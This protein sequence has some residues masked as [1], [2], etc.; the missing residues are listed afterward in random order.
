MV[1]ISNSSQKKATE[2]LLFHGIW[3]FKGWTLEIA[4]NGSPLYRKTLIKSA[5]DLKNV[6]L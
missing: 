2:L 6:L 4:G 5:E 3:D 1:F